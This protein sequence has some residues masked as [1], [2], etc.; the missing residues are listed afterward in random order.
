M[1]NLRKVKKNAPMVSVVMSAYNAERFIG[2]AI[3]SIL[4]QTWKDF[5]FIIIDDCSRDNTPKLIN[6]YARIDKRIKS[7]KNKVNL[8][9]CLSLDRGM[10]MARGK[11]LAV[12]DNDDWSYPDRLKKQV[13]FFEKHPDVGVVGGTMEIMN[14]KGIVSTKRQY[15]QSDADIR[16]NIFRYSPFSH[17]L[18]MIRRSVLEIVGYANCEFAPADDYEMYFRIGAVSK[19]ANLN[20]TILKYRTVSN[21]LTQRYARKMILTSIKTRNTYRKAAGYHMR[22]SDC[23]FDFFLRI[24]A[25]IFPSNFIIST[26]NLIRNIKTS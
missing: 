25:F 20:D 17:P 1:K 3:Q 21:S 16:K 19:F 22:L 12:M 18:I 26:F 4:N 11:Y 2:E 14:E 7:F 13:N 6:E 15:H 10:K 8:G 5:D 23:V 9:G 24:C